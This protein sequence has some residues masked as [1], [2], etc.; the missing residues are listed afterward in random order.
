[1]AD[2][3]A[4]GKGWA[5]AAVLLASIVSLFGGKLWGDFHASQ[6]EKRVTK[7][8]EVVKED[9]KDGIDEVK[10]MIRDLSRKVDRL[11]ERER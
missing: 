8:V 10:G 11:L 7:R 1:M 9:A 5:F 6:V 3:N 2:G 4:N